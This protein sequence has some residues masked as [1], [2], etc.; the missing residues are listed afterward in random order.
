MFGSV[1]GLIICGE[2]EWVTTFLVPGQVPN[3]EEIE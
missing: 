1:P 3:G 2:S